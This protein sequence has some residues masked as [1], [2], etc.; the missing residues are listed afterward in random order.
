[1][2]RSNE[3]ITQAEL[4]AF[5]K[6]ANEH[7][8]ELIG[9]DGENNGAAIGD[10]FLNLWKEDINA[11]TLP[12]AVEQL[13]KAGRL[14]FKSAAKAK[15]DQA[16]QGVTH[17]QYE[18]FSAWLRRQRLV[19][20][21]DEGYENAENILTWI[22]E[23]N[24]PFDDHSFSQALSNITNNGHLGHANLHWHKKLQDS[25]REAQQKREAESQQPAR[26]DARTELVGE[27]TLAPHLREH[28]RQM[29]A[30]LAEAEARKTKEGLQPAANLDAQWK[31]RAEDAV[32]SVQSNIDRAEAQRLLANG[33][34][35]G[36]ELTY[37]TIVNFMD[38]RKTQRSLAGR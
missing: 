7:N 26:Q 14:V 5:E 30:A 25:E 28:R 19:T 24:A 23:K 36:Y 13:R 12:H 17:D 34:R 6:F 21:G 27:S 9:I 3:T 20:T 2:A 35:W 31:Q 8:I 38:K 10:Y 33:G 4:D 11:A 18:K 1:M 16:V 29:Q 22:K 37:K 32:A 15:F